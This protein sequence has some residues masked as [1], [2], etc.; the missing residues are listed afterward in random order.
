MKPVLGII[1]IDVRAN[2]DEHAREQLLD[3]ITNYKGACIRPLWFNWL[4]G[5]GD[6]RIVCMIHDLRQLDG[7]LIE[8][9][10]TI[11]GV[12]GTSSFLA[13]DGFVQPDAEESITPQDSPWTRRAAATVKIVT[14]AGQDQAVYEA[15]TKLPPHNQVEMVFVAKLF[16]CHACDLLVLLLGERTASLTGYVS[17]WIRTIPGVEDTQVFSTLDWKVVAQPEDFMDMVM[18]FSPDGSCG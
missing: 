4:R 12:R 15:L 5:R 6:L 10:R 18:C 9:I 11:P 16:H 8:Q 13:F 17:S 14:A 7:F 3:R 1:D 2:E